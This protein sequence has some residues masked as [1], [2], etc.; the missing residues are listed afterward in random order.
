M[1][2]SISRR[3]AKSGNSSL[4]A[5]A[6]S[7]V[8]MVA[9]SPS[10]KRCANISFVMP[11]AARCSLIDAA[12]VGLAEMIAVCLSCDRFAVAGGSSRLSTGFAFEFLIDELALTYGEFPFS[13]R[14]R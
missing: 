2:S 11:T 4:L 1:S 14:A 12:T 10:K 5:Y 3:S 8:T 13:T 6:V 7:R 9:F